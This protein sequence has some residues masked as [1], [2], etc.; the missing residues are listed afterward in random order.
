MWRI[1]L[2]GQI[3]AV[4]PGRVV[5]HFRTRQTAA[6]LAYLALFADR[7]HSRDALADR[8]WP[9]AD[10]SAARHRLSVA[11][12]S[13]R[14]ALALPELPADD[15]LLAS[16]DTVQLNPSLVT[17]DVADFHEAHERTYTFRL[18]DTPVEF[19]TY[20]LSAIADVPRA[21]FRPLAPDGRAVDAAL[22]GRRP[23]DFGE[24]G[25]H[26]AGVFERELLPPGAALDGPL[27]VEEPT[28][29]TLVHPGQRL[30]VDDFGFLHI[31]EA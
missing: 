30:T 17:T 23:V 5:S 10:T 26:E 27:V 2:L 14:A 8:F 3:R 11:L 22:K 13:L 20:R 1:E 29:T 24:D 7:A 25:R 15:L 31:R 21:K 9:E 16:R 19:V 12:S 18:D 4:G 28:S 6:L